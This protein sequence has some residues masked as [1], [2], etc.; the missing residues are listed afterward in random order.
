MFPKEL[1]EANRW[2]GGAVPPVPCLAAYG[3]GLH[4]GRRGTAFFLSISTVLY[5]MAEGRAGRIASTIGVA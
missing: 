5:V 3:L 1:L 2:L 4:P